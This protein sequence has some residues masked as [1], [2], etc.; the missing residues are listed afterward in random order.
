MTSTMRFDK[1]E[2][3]NGAIIATASGGNIKYPSAII[4]I[5]QGTD[6]VG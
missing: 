4:Q 5:V 3:P 1:W 2:D 6:S